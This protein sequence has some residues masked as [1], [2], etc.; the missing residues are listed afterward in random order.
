[1]LISRSAVRA[2]TERDFN[3]Y[4]WM[5]RL[6]R[7]DLLQELAGF[8]VKPEFKT[9]PWLHQLVCFY[10]GLCEP[11]FL[12]LLD[13]GLGKSKIGLDLIRHRQRE[14]SLRR[15]L[16]AV[17]RLINI[18]SWSDDIE[19]HSTLEPN[20]IMVEDIEEKWRRL[21]EP[22]G[23]L[24]VID[25]HG[26]SLAVC[27][28]KRGRLI[29]DEKKIERLKRL[30][31][32]IL[33]D[34]S[35]KLQNANNLWFSIARDLTEHADFRYATTGTLFG[36]NVEGLWSQFFL[37]DGGETFGENLSL[38]RAS[39]FKAKPHAWKGQE[40]IFDK[41]KTRQLHRMINHRSI[42]Y[43]DTEV[44]ELPKM[45]RIPLRL[46][47]GEEQREHYMRAVEGIINAKGGDPEKIEAPWIKLRQISSGYLRWR[48]ELGSH[49]IHFKHNPKL[50]ALERLIDEMGDSKI[51]VPYVYTP[52]GE[53]IVKRLKDLGI[54]CEW[55]WGGT[56][57]KIACRRR[58][59][60]DPGCKA[61]IMNA[62]AG[63]TGNDGLQKVAR[64]MYFFESPTPPITRKQ[65]EKRMHR[66]GQEWRSYCYDPILKRSGDQTILDNLAE[67]R[68]LFEGIMRGRFKREDFLA[69]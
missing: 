17:P 53:M 27:T 25:Y 16:V 43:E 9:E 47:M 21:S 54:D 18:D 13:M 50:L 52:T 56:K 30:Y 19:R 48:D 26:L 39:F 49:I 24:S 62:E 20:C 35:H 15:A 1:M 59:M 66:P 3:S 45:M 32:F 58:F 36:R 42:R 14:R 31:N 2:F 57:D 38:L 23:D 10:I 4:L 60:E 51:I 61:F 22:R 5:K 6:S 11:E 55:L 44:Q 33:L 67:G 69:G 41:S 68:D 37:V 63:G 28:K 29:K 34:E 7:R 65:T 8:S 40:F 12:F 46:E 64:Y